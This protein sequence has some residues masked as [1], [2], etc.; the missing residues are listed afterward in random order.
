MGLALARSR[1]PDT[2]YSRV[3]SW[4]RLSFSGGI[5]GKSESQIGAIATALCVA[6]RPPAAP[7]SAG[8]SRQSERRARSGQAVLFR[9]GPAGPDG[10]QR[11]FDQFCR[12]G[13]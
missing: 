8:L 6:A 2:C 4:L 12:V 5:L 3:R 7:G 11:H 10:A 9:S 1:S 13:V